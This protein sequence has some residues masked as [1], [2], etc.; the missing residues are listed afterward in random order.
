LK[1]SISESYR[2]IIS[3]AQS[4]RKDWEELKSLLSRARAAGDIQDQSILGEAFGPFLRAPKSLC[5]LFDQ[6]IKRLAA[7]FGKT[8]ETAFLKVQEEMNQTQHAASINWAMV[9]CVISL[10]ADYLLPTA[11]EQDETH[12]LGKV[13]VDV[14]HAYFMYM[15]GKLTTDLQNQEALRKAADSLIQGLTAKE[16]EGSLWSKIWLQFEQQHRKVHGPVRI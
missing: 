6:G 1:H 15:K 5:I 3:Q 14:E 4:D 8:L 13:Y 9:S 11:Y 16:E 12:L 10:W 2:N 7:K